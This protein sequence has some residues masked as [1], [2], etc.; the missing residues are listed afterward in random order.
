MD[1]VVTTNDPSMLEKT[2][3]IRMSV[4]NEVP[5]EL[6]SFNAE[7][8]EGE[9]TLHWQTATE[10]N[11]SGFQIERLKDSKIE[12]LNDWEEIGFVDGKGTTT[13]AQ[14][15]IYKDK[16]I[17]PGKY[18][19]RLKQIDFDG[20]V[21]YSSE[22]EVEVSGPSDFALYQNYPN[23]F[24]PSTKIKFALPLK[25]NVVISIYNSI[26]EKVAEAF[27]G[28]LET[29]YHE[30]D[31]NAERLSSGVYIYRIESEKFV[32]SKKMLLLK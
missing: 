25:T 8:K 23:P 22:I 20:T 13:E 29:G 2:I 3:P 14:N 30:V 15:Y 32:S 28:D 1:M 18:N 10:T 27:R 12:K 31:F 16:N 26:G 19:Y 4:T 21:S 6:V 5:V 17:A 24:N 7:N 11:N 9:V